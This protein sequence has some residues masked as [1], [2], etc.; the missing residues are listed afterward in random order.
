MAGMW[1]LP[2]LDLQQ[3]NGDRP[4]LRVR[5]SITDT[6]YQVS[7]FAAIRDE[8]PQVAT[9]CRWLTAKQCEQLPLTGLTR[10]ILRKLASESGA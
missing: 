10:K 7:V 1:E 2:A 8:L 9:D 4:L 6:D 5:H 3:R